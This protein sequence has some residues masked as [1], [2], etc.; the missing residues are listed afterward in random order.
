M[1]PHRGVLYVFLLFFVMYNETYVENVYTI[2]YK[3]YDRS[4]ERLNIIFLRFCLLCI[5]CCIYMYKDSWASVFFISSNI[6]CGGFSSGSS[7]TY[8]SGFGRFFETTPCLTHDAIVNL[9]LDMLSLP[10]WMCAQ[11]FVCVLKI[12]KLSFRRCFISSLCGKSLLCLSL[13]L[14]FSAHLYLHISTYLSYN[15]HAHTHTETRRAELFFRTHCYS[16]YM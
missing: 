13:P 11:L 9:Q 5:S 12:Y 6:C 4:I 7:T 14:S 2:R 1:S 16:K 3:C 15:K 10:I 8:N